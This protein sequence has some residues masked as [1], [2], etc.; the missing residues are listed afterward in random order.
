MMPDIFSDFSLQAV[1]TFGL[2]ARASA[3]VTVSSEPELLDV[4]RA[5]QCAG[6][7]FVI[8]GEGSNTVFTGDVDALV[9]RVAL[10]GLHLLPADAQSRYLQVQAGENWHELVEWTLLNC[11]PGLENLALIPGSVGACPVQNIGAYGLEVMERIDCVRILDLQSLEFKSLS[12]QQCAFSYRDSIF[13]HELA[14]R[15]V[16]TQVTFRLPLK[17]QAVADYA[18][19]RQYLINAGIDQPGPRDVFN[20]VV[21]VRTQKL[22][23][24]RV[25]GNAGSFF[26]NPI[27]DAATYQGLHVRFPGL[28]AYAQPDG[29]WKLAA[30]WL[31][32][33]A[34]LKGRSVGGAAVSERQA[35]VLI[36]RGNASAADLRALMALVTHTVGDKFGVRLEPEPVQVA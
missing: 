10:K 25:M 6:T 12:A 33:Q 28:V 14:G 17:W 4:I 13:K 2:R 18:D 22:P 29:R 24:P 1:H 16:I 26:K 15:A 11:L 30:G 3:F 32:D 36:N 8:L 7:R 5:C 9:I 21:A 20:A 35:L 23:D 34:G 27:V 31:I 19:I